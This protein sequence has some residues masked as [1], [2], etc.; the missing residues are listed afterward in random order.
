MKWKYHKADLC[1]IGGGLA[2]MCTAI[3]AARHG[4]KVVLMHDRP[5]LGGNASSEIRMWICGA[6]G[7]NN[8]ETGIIEEIELEN[9]YRNPTRNYSIWDSILYEKVRFEENITL[10]LNCSCNSL[11]MNGSRIKSVKGWQLTTETWHTVEAGLFADC[12]GDSILAPLCAAEHRIG[13][14][15]AAEFG[16]DIEP[17]QADKKTMGM[18]CL[19]QA[20]E[21]DRP[22]K[23][24]PPSWAYKY[25]SDDDLPYRDHDVRTSNFWWI[26][27]GGDQD[28][29]HDTEEI[30]DELLKIA[31]GV[32]DHIKNHGDHGADN[33][34]LDWVGFLPGKR[35]SRRYIGD[36]IMTQNDVRAEGRFEDVVAYGGWTMD[37]HHPAGFKYPGH[38]TIWHP[39]PSPF[40]IPYRCLYS[41][42]IDNLFF[43]GRN[44]SVTH[45]A[46]SATRVMATCAILGQAVGTA[47]AIAIRNAL[48]P[49]G[50]Y[51][52]K[53]DEL[54]QALMEDDCY[55]P[56]K[57]RDIPELIKK[58]GL[59]AS[60]GDPE[61]LRNGLDRPIGEEDNGWTGSIGSWV[62]YTFKQS[63]KIREIRF[64]FDSDLNRTEKVYNKVQKAHNMPCNYPLD[65]EPLKVP[66]SMTRAFRIEAKDK[67]GQWKTVLKVDNNYQRLVKLKVNIETTAIRFI[68]E[69]TWGAERVHVFSWDVR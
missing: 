2:G 14:E 47:A 62:Q 3:A 50:V 30:R 63:E 38:P 56:W 1:V 27:L 36:Y 65:S 49:R 64:V 37:D 4:A 12:S 9:M 51:E 11:E 23:F 34:V 22:Q 33:W 52:N 8:R 26:E 59:I 43:A 28:S 53:I 40:G 13:R 15:A 69:A 18:S 24:N 21:T 54:Q 29:I 55:L 57:R 10:L 35:E 7:E 32:W 44:I 17:E 46:M 5:V 39:A 6:H 41:R 42:N 31:F 67:N 20:R 58:A 66:E 60:E 19:I 61:P 25:L 48:K 68:P 45:A 16:E